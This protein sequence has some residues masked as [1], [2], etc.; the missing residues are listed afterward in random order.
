[1][2]GIRKGNFGNLERELWKSENGTLEISPTC[3]WL[4][5]P[6]RYFSPLLVVLNRD[7][8]LVLFSET[9]PIPLV[10]LKEGP[11]SLAKLWLCS[12]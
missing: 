1:M 11:R 4:V 7:S 10:T 12:I 8:G 9:Y 2:V 6:M 5:S 3:F